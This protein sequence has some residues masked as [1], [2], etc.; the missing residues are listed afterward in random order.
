VKGK[1][2]SFMERKPI[3]HYRIPVG[4]ELDTA[5]NELKWRGQ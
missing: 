4:E 5:R 2:I 3:W 1:G